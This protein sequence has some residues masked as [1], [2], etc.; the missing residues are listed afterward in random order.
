MKLQ[1]GL[2]KSRLNKAGLDLEVSE[3]AITQLAEEGYDPHFGA[4]E[5]RRLIQKEIENRISDE[6]LKKKPERGTVI[7]V[8][9]KNKE[10]A[11]SLK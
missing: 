5:L 3:E 6:I 8:D 9:F 4:R 10:F 7:G 11:L 1:I 2:L